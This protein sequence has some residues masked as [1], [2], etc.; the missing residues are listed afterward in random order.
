MSI[1]ICISSFLSCPTPPHTQFLMW[2]QCDKDPHR[3]CENIG[4]YHMSDFTVA[5]E[6]RIWGTHHF[7]AK[8]KQVWDI[9]TSFTVAHC[10]YNSDKC[11]G[12]E[13]L[14]SAFLVYSARSEGL[15]AHVRLPLPTLGSRNNAKHVNWGILFL[16]VDHYVTNILYTLY[17]LR[18]LK[19][20]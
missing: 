3:C 8:H 11:L 19:V 16:L 6:H 18:L 13:H 20:S 1:S 9:S 14:G 15:R 4:L 2:G 12:K 17:S 7:V 10:K 5:K